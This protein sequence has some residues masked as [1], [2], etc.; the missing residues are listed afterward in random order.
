MQRQFLVFVAILSFVFLLANC[1][2][3]K[4]IEQ[5][6]SYSESKVLDNDLL[7]STMKGPE[8]HYKNF[9]ASCHGAKMKTFVD[10][11]KWS[12]GQTKQALTKSIK[13]GIPNAGMPA[14]Q[15]TFTDSELEAL[16]EYIFQGIK[17]RASFER[18]N[19]DTPK[20]YTSKYQNLQI[21]TVVYNIEVPWGIK[22]AKDGTIFFTERKG[23]LQLRKPD[24]TIVKIKNTPEVR[25]ANQGGMLDV[26]LHP[27]FEN[28]Q[29]LYLSYSKIHE[30]DEDLCTT[31][32]L[33]AKL[34]GDAL[35]EHQEIFEALPYSP[36]RHHFGCRL[37]FDAQGF[38][39]ITIGDRGARDEN[40]QSLLNA[41]G[42]IHRVKEDGQ[43][44]TDNPF[45]NQ[46]GAVKSIWTY[47]NR[48]P[49]GLVFDKFTGNVWE[50]E[51][52]PKGGDELNIVKKGANYGWPEVSYGINYNGTIFTD[53]TEREDVEP[54]LNFWIPSIAP[55]GMA[56]V[57]GDN[58]GEWEGDILT[59]SLR[60]HYVSRIRM[61]GLS[62]V[63]E[64][65]IFKDIGRV[66]AIEMGADGF[67]YIGVE[68]PG[69]I[70]KVS[71]V[72]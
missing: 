14:Y 25:N 59:G 27:D 31:A 38:L 45:Y 65:K 54:P 40:P 30:D 3:S 21:D 55:S 61:D 24:G 53:Q 36:M 47:G 39:Y 68:D 26:A 56:L 67:L 51:H 18:K 62:L 34:V 5:D 52:G 42:K 49:Q 41:C 10:R 6:S 35:T 69:R 57:S 13:F 17:E 8:E 1:N 20:Y 60:F 29:W 4:T 22:V 72:K 63:E 2:A 58:Y 11:R 16:V 12:Y 9:C 70:L 32:V 15:K 46:E 43:I 19:I 64:E 50:H 37:V 48:N 33:R 7:A 23:T 66:R 28:N 44:P 71:V